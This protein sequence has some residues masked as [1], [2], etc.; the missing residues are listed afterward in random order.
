MGAYRN[1]RRIVDGDG[2]VT[3][4]RFCESK[5]HYQREVFAL[6][7]MLR[8]EMETTKYTMIIDETETKEEE[9][10]EGA[11]TCII[12]EI[13]FGIMIRQSCKNIQIFLAT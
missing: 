2:T 3:R 10:K 11:S 8:K 9:G 13:N 12:E 5:F 4:G 6:N 1:C 7:K